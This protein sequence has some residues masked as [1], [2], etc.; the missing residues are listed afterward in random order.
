MSTNWSRAHIYQYA[1]FAVIT[2]FMA[3]FMVWPIALTVRC[4]FVDTNDQFTLEYMLG[5]FR[6]PVTLTA[7][8]NSIAI[9]ICTTGLCLALAL[10][11]SMLATR[12]EFMGKKIVTSLIL[13]PLILPPFVGAIGL[14]AVLG[15]F[16]ALNSLLAW[17]GIIDANGVGLDF[18]GSDTASG[19]F[20]SVVIMETL[21]LYPI[22][23]LNI[24]AALA[25]I[26]PTLEEA[27]SS[28]GAGSW[29]RLRRV[30]LPLIMP[31]I[32][33][34]TTIVFI[35][36]FTE[37]GT[38]LM[39]NYYAVAPVQ[40]FWHI[41]EVQS[42][43]QPYALVVVM[44][45][46]AVGLY[47]LSKVTTGRRPF[48]MQTRASITGS[49]K[50]LSGI[51]SLAA[52]MLFVL[53]ISLA[54]AP[55]IGVVL[56]SISAKGAWYQSIL[57]DNFT[58]EHFQNAL[59]HTLATGSIRNSLIY[60]SIAT[61]VCLVLG[62]AIAY[63]NIRTRI[64][65]GWLLDMLAMLPLA[66]PGLVI[67]FGYVTMTLHWP[68][69]ENSVLGHW[70]SV[71]GRNP[72]PFTLLVI[73]YAIR[74]LP[75]VVRSVSAG[76][77]QTSGD[78]EEAAANLGAG[79]FTTIRRIVI[80]LIAVN[81]IAGAILAF[82]F[83]MLEVSDSL[84]LAQK[85]QHYPITKAIYALFDRLGDGPYIASAMGVWAMVLLT[86]TLISATLMLGKRMGTMF[87]L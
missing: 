10:P 12:Y 59:S 45:S 35:W 3:V 60:A 52:A 24:T 26:D 37:L 21:H 63:L 75:Y 70:F 28:L 79:T 55:H 22:A 16:G 51:L 31:G 82:S 17:L 62:F 69:D 39:L 53:I 30:T 54:I 58:F 67:A 49:T 8:R 4:G 7:L 86:I 19:Q 47:L 40:I 13:V 74:R 32:F 76:L 33:A 18:L 36:S 27:A 14:R 11:L 5:I 20:W 72:N 23:Y 66:V 85:E 83:S 80:P 1:L 77:E 87:R 38:P 29:T 57:P 48:A 78:L 41:N 25:N 15:R 73:A 68:F 65:G 42:N 43:P 71:V 46:V 50:R 61:T 34:G 84:I 81:L 44:L 9:A 56:S 64:T 6:D 2:A